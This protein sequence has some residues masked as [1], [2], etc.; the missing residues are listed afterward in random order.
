MLYCIYMRYVHVLS[1][2]GAWGDGGVRGSLWYFFWGFK[3]KWLRPCSTLW[4]VWIFFIRE[5]GK[6]VWAYILSRKGTK[7]M[8]FCPPFRKF[9]CGKGNEIENYAVISINFNYINVVQL[10]ILPMYTRLYLCAI[11]FLAFPLSSPK[12]S[13]LLKTHLKY[14]IKH[15][16]FKVKWMMF[17]CSSVYKMPVYNL[18][19]L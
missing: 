7:G 14:K 8:G 10:K 18:L 3:Y 9:W 2:S 15:H 6:E 1:A 17:E 11:F 19:S 12:M 13:T 4:L 5:G 16:F